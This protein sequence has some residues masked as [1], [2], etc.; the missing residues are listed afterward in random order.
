MNTTIRRVLTAN[1]LSRKLYFAARQ[2]YRIHQTGKIAG[3]CFLNPDEFKN[4][5][6]S[7]GDRR[8]RSPYS[9][10][11]H[12]HNQEELRRCDDAR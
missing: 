12:N 9:R 4:A 7:S 8:S 6:G 2:A 1:S 5:L 10:R 3:R 11:P